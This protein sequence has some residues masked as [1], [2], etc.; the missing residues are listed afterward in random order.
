MDTKTVVTLLVS[1][2]LAV[3][4]YIATYLNTLR[5]TKR[6]E[7]LDRLDRQLRELYGP[8]YALTESAEK[9]WIAFRRQ[10]KRP[11]GSFWYA[12]PPLNEAEKAAWRLWMTH[13]LMP[14]NLQI[15]TVIVA[16]SDLLVGTEMPSSLLDLLAH[17]AAY[18]A[19]I[20]A[21][22]IEDYSHHLSVIDYPAEVNVYA[23]RIYLDL[24]AQQQ[25]LIGL[26][27]SASDID[28]ASAA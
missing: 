25:R 26:T 19:V 20:K 3:S 7:R 14:I 22:E 28:T 9:S 8:L 2:L 6:R 4:G 10:I 21:W 15:E 5:L 18:K 12:D 24:K 17:I 13:V 23:K 16:K 11:E 1:V 27:S